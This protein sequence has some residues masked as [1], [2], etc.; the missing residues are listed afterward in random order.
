M[1][2]LCIPRTLAKIFIVAAAVTTTNP[3]L[4]NGSDWRGRVACDKGQHQAWCKWPRVTS[5]VAR[6]VGD[7]VVVHMPIVARRQKAIAEE[8]QSTNLRVAKETGLEAG[9]GKVREP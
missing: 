5:V 4:R 1:F 6:V 9:Q 8:S 2:A 7:D 3:Q